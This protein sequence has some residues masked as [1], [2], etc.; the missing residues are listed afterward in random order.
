MNDIE[1]EMWKFPREVVKQIC[2]VLRGNINP[3]YLVCDRKYNVIFVDQDFLLRFQHHQQIH[4]S[5]VLYYAKEG[6]K[7]KI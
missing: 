5:A 3:F 6:V 1:C 2:Y 4:F 7:D